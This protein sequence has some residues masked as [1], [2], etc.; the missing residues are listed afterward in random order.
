MSDFLL[1]SLIFLVSGAVSFVLFFGVLLAV[2]HWL[3]VRREA[4]RMRAIG[5]ALA[6]EEN[7]NV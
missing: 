3:D 4:R 1:G 5:R 6:R 2:L 7:R